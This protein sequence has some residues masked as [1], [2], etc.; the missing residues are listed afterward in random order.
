LTERVNT[1]HKYP[2]NNQDMRGIGAVLLSLAYRAW[3]DL[4]GGLSVGLYILA[5]S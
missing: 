5:P 4:G 3:A 2:Q 1:T